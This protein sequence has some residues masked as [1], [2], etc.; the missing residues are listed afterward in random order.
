MEYKVT[1]DIISRE[2]P[3]KLQ[4]WDIPEIESKCKLI[5]VSVIHTGIQIH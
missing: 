3:V 1:Q 5:A 2:I 4:R